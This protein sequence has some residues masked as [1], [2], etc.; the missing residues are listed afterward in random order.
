MTASEAPTPDDT[1]TASP[2]PV[3]D[4]ASAPVGDRRSRRRA[5][6]REEI[7]DI[8]LDL[9]AEE[10]VAGLSL[11]AVA[12]HLGIRP[13][14]LYKYF[15]SRHAVY[16]ALF[17]RGQEQYRDTVAAAAARAPE[18]G[19]A[20]IGAAFDA[21]ARWIMRNQTLSQ[22]LFWRPVPKFAPTPQAYAP[23][24]D[25]RDLMR[26]LVAAA[27][28]RGELHPLA[29]A[30]EGL[31]LLAALITGPVSQQL[32]NE[33]DVAFEDGRYMRLVARLPDLFAA[34]YPPADTAR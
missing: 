34:A 19:L 3:S 24:L 8:A 18:P 7:L 2:A 6:T 20:A 33:P 31:D 17:Q 4:P 26:G 12:R 1:A 5:E 9:M 27:V 22:L 13:P 16:D 11:A 30:P 32:A 23:A 21:G 10:G 25:I 28:D 14:S 29:A 15:P